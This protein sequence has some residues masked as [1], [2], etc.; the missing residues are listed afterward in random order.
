LVQTVAGS[1]AIMP[2]GC[3]FVGVVSFPTPFGVSTTFYAPAANSQLISKQINRYR[4]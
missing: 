4:P 1:M 2:L 3:G